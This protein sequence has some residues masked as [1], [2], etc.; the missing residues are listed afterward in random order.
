MAIRAGLAAGWLSRRLGLGAGVIIGGRVTLALAPSALSRLAAGRLV[1]LVSGTNGK[2]TT[3]HLLAAALRTA[4]RVAHNASGA[5]MAD[6]AVAALAA[7]PDA[8]VAVLEID[9]LH[10]AAVAAAVDPAVVVL[11]NLSRDQLDRGCEVRAVAAAVGGAL[12]A[13][14]RTVTV[15]NADDPMVVWAATQSPR[16]STVWVSTRGRWNGDATSCPRCGT[17][18]HGNGDRW[19][20]RCG[21][22]RPAPH[23]E[24]SE[25]AAVTRD[26]LVIPVGLR[27]PG[28]FNLG[29][30]VTAMAAAELLGVDPRRAAAAMSLLP[31]VAGRY[32]VVTYR[33][34]ELRLLLAKNPAGWAEIL[35][36]LDEARPLLVVVN[37]REA[38]GRDTSW[39]WDV[40]F[41][42]IAGRRVV[43]AGEH[44]ADVGVRLTYAE[45]EH[46]T[47]ADPLA[48][49]ALLP[50][51][52]VDVVANYTAF[53]QLR[54]RLT[55]ETAGGEPTK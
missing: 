33:E 42:E 52:V 18:L 16:P 20:C 25:A 11:L 6:G 7:D 22:A 21:L 10:L 14:P 5:N 4:G 36:V 45:I 47:V 32:A 54:R 12:A 19:R 15:A 29:N 46:D 31:D 28:R 43:A 37:A 50:T 49:L 38:D 53:H 39:L 51:G 30:A 1:V 3:S 35:G 48:G 55:A 17:T 26:G 34:R 9:E 24:A 2:T 8:P 44:A 23:W 40:P 27:L 41:D 13:H